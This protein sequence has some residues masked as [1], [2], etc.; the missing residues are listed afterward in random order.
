MPRKRRGGKLS[1]YRNGNDGKRQKVV[2]EKVEAEIGTIEER[3]EHD[4]DVPLRSN[5][6]PQ[7]A[8]VCPTQV[9]ASQTKPPSPATMSQSAS[10]GKSGIYVR[11][12]QITRR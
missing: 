4:D 10:F 2:K 6:V 1:R 11:G 12:F 3:G 8:I 7:A 5:D 9:A